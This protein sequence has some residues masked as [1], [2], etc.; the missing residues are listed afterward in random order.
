MDILQSEVKQQKTNAGFYTY[1]MNQYPKMYYV[2][3]IFMERKCFF[4]LFLKIYIYIYIL[5][6]TLNIH[7]I[8]K[9]LVTHSTKLTLQTVNTDNCS[10]H[11]ITNGILQ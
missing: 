3:C 2:E 10:L 9:I 4:F 7:F 1:A 8:L 5:H 11:Y 6:I